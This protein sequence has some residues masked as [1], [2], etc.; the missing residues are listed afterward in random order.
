KIKEEPKETLCYNCNKLKEN[1]KSAFKK[2][3]KGLSLI[4][5]IIKLQK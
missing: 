2:Y 1:C 3:N 5:N 4:K